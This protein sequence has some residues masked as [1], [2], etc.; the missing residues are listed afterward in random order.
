M[1]K[2]FVCKHHLIENILY[3]RTV[4]E[5]QAIDIGYNMEN[6]SHSPFAR[7]ISIW[8]PCPFKIGSPN[9][10]ACMSHR[11][12]QSSLAVTWVYQISDQLN[13][14]EKHNKNKLKMM[15]LIRFSVFVFVRCPVVAVLRYNEA[16]ATDSYLI[17]FPKPQLFRYKRYGETVVVGKKC[18]FSVHIWNVWW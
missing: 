16:I 18:G 12:T 17:C 9:K 7:L 8:F 4:I 2:W 6:S 11:Y 1:T 3:I 14:L 10:F 13:Y 15:S 5:W